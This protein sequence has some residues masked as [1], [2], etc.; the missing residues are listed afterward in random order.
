MCCFL[1]EDIMELHQNAVSW[2]HL[3][4]NMWLLVLRWYIFIY[5]IWSILQKA[6]LRNI[7]VSLKVPVKE[8]KTAKSHFFMGEMKQNL[9]YPDC[10]HLSAVI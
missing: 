7:R 10:W 8:Q 4:L 5:S 1:G 9:W 3:Q 6:E 2:S